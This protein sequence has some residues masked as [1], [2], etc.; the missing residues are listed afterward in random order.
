MALVDVTDAFDTL[1]ELI[2]IQNPT[3]GQLVQGEWV[4]GQPTSTPTNAVVLPLSDG[5]E[6]LLRSEGHVYRDAKYF[7]IEH[8]M[9]SVA[10]E[11]ETNTYTIVYNNISYHIV[12]LVD[13][14]E[15]GGYIQATGISEVN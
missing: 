12:R 13:Y 15:M 14:F 1:T 7:F 10:P 4:D 6:A 3:R 9:Q 8:D 5:D 11:N 2:V